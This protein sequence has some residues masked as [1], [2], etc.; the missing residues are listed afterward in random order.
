MQFHIKQNSPPLENILVSPS[1]Y[2]F[3][4]VYM[5]DGGTPHPNGLFTNH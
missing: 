2:G 3:M 1:V 5:R 4:Y